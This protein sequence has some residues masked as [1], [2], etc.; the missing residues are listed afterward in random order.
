MQ[1][2]VVAIASW[3][4]KT[5]RG[6]I[7]RESVWAYPFIQ[8]IHFTGLSIWLGTNSALGLRLL[9]IGKKD[10]AAAQVARGLFV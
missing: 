5:P 1:D 9:G 4:E 3:L 8:L 2:W 6:L 7:T 10:A